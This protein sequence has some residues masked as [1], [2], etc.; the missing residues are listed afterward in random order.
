MGRPL[1]SR[2]FGPDDAE[3][4]ILGTARIPGRPAAVAVYVIRQRSS[5]KFEVAEVAA[6]ANTGVVI[7][8]NTATPAEGEFSIPVEPSDGAGGS[9][10]TEY[11]KII[12]SKRVRTFDD[13]AYAW[14]DLTIDV[15]GEGGPGADFP[16]E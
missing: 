13:N 6:P 1:N 2:Y 10:G 11:A 7:T 4:Q 5:R 8:A 9:T 14:G 15:V 3:E 12:T 16:A